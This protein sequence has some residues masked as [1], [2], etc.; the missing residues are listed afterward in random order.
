[1]VDP[2]AANKRRTWTLLSSLVTVFA[3][4]GVIVDLVVGTLPIVTIVLLAVGAALAVLALRRADSWVLRSVGAAP[5]DAEVHKR[6]HN[7]VEGLC[8]ANGL[9]KP[10]VYVVDD[11]APNSLAVGRSPRLASLVVTSGLLE[12][13]NRVELEGVVAHELAH[14]RN[15]DTLASTTAALVLGVPAGFAA[16]IFGPLLRAFV[17]TGR[18][19]LADISGCQMT[20]YPPGLL[21]ALE[22][23]ADESVATKSA[24]R[25]T[26]HLWL[27]DTAPSE[28]SA[29]ARFDAHP[30]IE[31][32]IALI[33]EL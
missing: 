32:R 8:L 30:A 20:R 14:I 16:P 25:A 9:S 7:L 5:A 6:L 15:H 13:M 3:L 1:M 4:L 10:S 33:R 31:E 23:I 11:P 26:A 19:S 17:G 21:S 22:K 27:A 24:T 2:I 12:K 28:G 18:E 29:T